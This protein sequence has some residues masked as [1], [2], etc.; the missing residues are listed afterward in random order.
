M[1]VRQAGTNA[2][3]EDRKTKK[4]RRRRGMNLPARRQ[5]GRRCIAQLFPRTWIK[6]KA[7]QLTTSS[8][9]KQRK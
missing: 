6:R 4:M 9:V 7:V 1:G 5:D 3:I 8:R 2:N